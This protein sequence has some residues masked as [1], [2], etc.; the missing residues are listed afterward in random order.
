[1]RGCIEEVEVK[2]RELEAQLQANA[3]RHVAQLRKI[4]VQVHHVEDE[5]QACQRAQQE[6]DKV[7]QGLDKKQ[8]ALDKRKEA[9]HNDEKEL[10]ICF[11][12]SMRD[13]SRA[14]FPQASRNHSAA[15]RNHAVEQQRCTPLETLEPSAKR[16]KP[17]LD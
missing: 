9:L 13:A 4:E 15:D 10:L 5:R 17:D 12:R 6:L 1:M 14:F 8:Q 11:L 7:R 16:Q 3:Q 2:T